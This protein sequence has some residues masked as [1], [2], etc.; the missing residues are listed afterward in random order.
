MIAVSTK[1]YSEQITLNT[2]FQAVAV[3]VWF[4]KPVTICSLYL[5]YLDTITSTSLQNLTAQLPSIFILTGDFNTHNELW[6]SMSTNTRGTV[7]KTTLLSSNVALFNNGQQTRFNIYTGH[8]SAIDLTFCSSSLLPQ[9]NWSVLSHSYTSDH[10]PQY[11]EIST[12]LS[13]PLSHHHESFK[14][15]IGNRLHS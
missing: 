11:L 5:H 7:L 9:L 13:L 10:F 6:G 8:Y 4:H 14:K 1:F 15:L 3:R 2:P 12:N